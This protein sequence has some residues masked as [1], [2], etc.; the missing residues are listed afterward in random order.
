MTVTATNSKG[1]AQA[2]IQV[3][4]FNPPPVARAGDDGYV[5]ANA[6][7][8]LN[9]SA[10]SDPNGDVPLTYQWTQVSGT[11]VSLSSNTASQPSFT[12][13]VS[14]G[15]L[16]FELRVRDAA[17]N[18]SGVDSVVITVT[19]SPLDGLKA[20][21]GTPALFNTVTPFT[22]TLASATG[23][24]FV[25]DF[26]DGTFGSGITSSHKYGA[27][28][29]YTAIVTATN[30]VITA[31]ATVLVKVVNIAPIAKAVPSQ[32]NAFAGTTL[33]L[34]AGDSID[35]NGNTPLTYNW[36]QVRGPPVTLNNAT[37]AAP[38]FIAPNTVTTTTITFRLVVFDSLGVPS[39]PVLVSIVIRPSSVNGGGRVIYMPMLNKNGP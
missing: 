4:V 34:N 9:G 17:G 14:V 29:I 33:T 3:I 13:P 11:A 28:G 35:P 32:V 18:D 16:T 31:S 24:S 1:S 5:L 23:V 26:G 36:V 15:A 2:T 30:G 39:T 21:A 22:A 25:W 7:Y 20:Y 10:S 38:T 19:N 6:L 27:L 12:A 8:T 37:S